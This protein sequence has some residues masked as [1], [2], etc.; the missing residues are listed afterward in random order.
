MTISVIFNDFFSSH[1]ESSIEQQNF[2]Q[3]TTRCRLQLFSRYSKRT[4]CLK[5][6]KK[7]PSLIAH[8]CIGNEVGMN[9]EH[10]T[11]FPRIFFKQPQTHTRKPVFMKLKWRRKKSRWEF[12]WAS[13]WNV[14]DSAHIFQ[15]S[16]FNCLRIFSCVVMDT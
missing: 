13:L 11:F 2:L 4:I 15:F 14:F 6:N 12:F 10:R 5:S 8:A 9:N 7:F 3:P 1:E 16:F